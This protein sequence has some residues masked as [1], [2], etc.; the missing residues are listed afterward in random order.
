MYQAAVT[1]TERGAYVSLP[2]NVAV[3]RL[4]SPPRQPETVTACNVT[5]TFACYKDKTYA[6]FFS[7]APSR[8]EPV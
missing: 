8:L 6:G 1:C 2:R 4:V 7:A 5:E 3:N